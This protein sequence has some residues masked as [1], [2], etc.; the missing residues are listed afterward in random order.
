MANF[1]SILNAYKPT[2]KDGRELK[3]TLSAAYEDIRKEFTKMFNEM[4]TEFLEI[5][6]T[7]DCKINDL[8]GEVNILKKRIIK[9]EDNID[10]QEAYE[11]RDT[12]IFSGDKLPTVAPH[13]NCQNIVSKLLE[14]NLNVKISASDISVSHRLGA[15]PKTQKPDKRKI[16]VK[17]CRRENKMN[18][19]RSARTVKPDKLFINESLTTQRQEISNALRRAKREL[20]HLVTGTTTLD[21]SVFVWT[22][23]TDATATRDTRHRINSYHR[24]E[25]FCQHTLHRSASHFLVQTSS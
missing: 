6:K 9:L 19:L 10:E 8:Q 23:S 22:K 2:T 13:E 5:N 21:G 25:E 12:L 3:T 20:P 18:I 17:F 11:R 1:T 4:R 24:L 7:K 14:E 15:K 16:I